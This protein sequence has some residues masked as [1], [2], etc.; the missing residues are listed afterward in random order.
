MKTLIT[1]TQ[2]HI[3]A[4]NTLAQKLREPTTHI[5]MT[6]VNWNTQK[7]FIHKTLNDYGDG[8]Y[9]RVGQYWR[10]KGIQ[11]KRTKYLIRLENMILEHGCCRRHEKKET[12]LTKS[13]TDT[14]SLITT[15]TLEAEEMSIYGKELE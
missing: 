8:P 15:T 2:L 14:T 7:L 10:K 5:T 13:S 12:T 4:V 11:P 6:L 9:M 1:T 3:M